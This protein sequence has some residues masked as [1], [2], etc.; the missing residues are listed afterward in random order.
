MFTYN[1]SD[2]YDFPECVYVSK[3]P[4]TYIEI[5]SCHGD[6]FFIGGG[7]Q[8]VSGVYYDTVAASVGCDSI[9]ITK[10]TV[11]VNDIDAGND[12]IICRGQ[13]VGLYAISGG[14]SYLWSPALGLSDPSIPDPIASPLVTTV[15]TVRSQIKGTNLIINGD[16][17]AGNTGFTSG[18]PYEPPPNVNHGRY[19]IYD[20]SQVWNTKM[21][22]CSDH[23]SGN[24]NMMLVN[25]NPTPNVPVWCQTI[26]V[27][28][29]TD[30]EFSTWVTTLFDP[31]AEL[32][33][34]ING[35]L[36]GPVFNSPSI[37]CVWA[38][39][40][41][42]WNSGADT[43]ANICIVNQST[44]PVGND[45]A[46]DDISFIPLCSGYDSVVVYVQPSLT[47]TII[48]SIC[49]GDSFFAAGGWQYQSG[50][51]VDTFTSLSGCDSI[52]V[53]HLS[54]DSIYVRVAEDTTIAPGMSVVLTTVSNA[55]AFE[56]SPAEGLS[57]TA[58]ASPVAKPVQ[59]ATYYVQASGQSGCMAV[60]SITIKVEHTDCK[61]VMPT[62]FSP[63]ADG[64][65][66][67]IGPLLSGDIR[68][69]DYR[70]FNRWGEQ[71]FETHDR[72][73]WW[74]GAWKGEPQDVAVYVYYVR[75]SCGN[76]L[77][78]LRGNITL[79]R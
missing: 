54:V 1:T 37:D 65:H 9:V 73:N 20:G 77:R 31:V 57:C 38:Q 53:T 52:I 50:V 74:D 64:V 21:A 70:V 26:K 47:D 12:L 5:F 11:G 45:F 17:S 48:K 34:L 46:L 7:W 67:R 13:S 41:A 59:T 4:S 36:I 40:A 60:D 28:A 29:N 43:I 51:Y 42:T 56:W 68:L 27:L 55:G 30:Y 62:A 10:L 3:A 44:V 8:T 61:I 75:Y 79:V 16:F 32:Q 71:V 76:T 58:C 18:Y 25:G 35:S 19:W 39:F 49:P 69:E 23:T 15:Y 22:Q 72:N 78:M 33:F 6:S 14:P 2:V 63:N 66:D 24:G